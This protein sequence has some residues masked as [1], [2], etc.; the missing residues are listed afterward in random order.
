MELDEFQKR[1][2]AQDRKLDAVFRL[3]LQ[4]DHLGRARSALQ[5]LRAGLAVELAF[6][7]LAVFAL[8]VFIGDHLAELC[9]ALPAVVLDVAAV[10]VLAST[11]RQWFLAGEVDFDS[12]VTA[13]QRRLEGLRV[14]RIRVTQWVLLLSPL[15]WTPLLVAA[16]RAL[17]GVDAYA[18]LGVPY[19]LANLLFGIAFV[20]LMGWAARRWANR[21]ERGGW[22]RRWAEAL[23]G[24][25][26]T[27]ALAQ[28]ASIADF[29]R[30]GE[31]RA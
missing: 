28:L 19:L 15:L 9:F 29:E 12:P 26:L 16:L 2:A 5:R 31:R 4:A 1:W 11:V 6:N 14:L 7:A 25:S 27:A 30:E 21:L 10:A 18:T 17:F 22:A 23:A 20:P 3:T 24:T 13:S 8:G